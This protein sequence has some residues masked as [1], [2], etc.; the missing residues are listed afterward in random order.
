MYMII[1]TNLIKILIDC[2]Y[3]LEEYKEYYNDII[4]IKYYYVLPINGNVM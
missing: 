1:L 2:V 3:V 4:S